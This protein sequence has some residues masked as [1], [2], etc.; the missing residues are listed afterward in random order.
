[1]ARRAY[2]GLPHRVN[3]R[4]KEAKGLAMAVVPVYDPG[5]GGQAYDLVSH[6]WVVIEPTWAAFSKSVTDFG[7]SMYCTSNDRFAIYTRWT[8]GTPR[9][10]VVW[11]GKVLAGDTTAEGYITNESAA[12]LVVHDMTNLDALAIRR[13]GG[14]HSYT[15]DG[16]IAAGQSFCAGYRL[17]VGGYLDQELWLD[18]RYMPLTNTGT[19]YSHTVG[20]MRIGNDGGDG[21]NQ[22][23]TIC[24]GWNQDLINFVDLT[25]DPWI[26][27]RPTLVAVGLAPLGGVTVQP[28]AVSFTLSV[29]TPA[30]TADANITA[31]FLTYVLSVQ[32]PT[33]NTG[34]TFTADVLSYTFTVQTPTVITSGNVTVTPDPVTCAFTVQTPTV[35]TNAIVTADVLS[36]TFTVQT[37]T[38]KTGAAKILMARRAYPGL[39]HRI[40]WSRKESKGLV[41]AVIPLYDTGS[42]GRAYNLV[43]REWVTI[44]P[45]WSTFSKEVTDF[46]PGMRCFSVAKLEIN[47][48]WTP[49][50]RYSVVWAGKILSGSAGAG[51]ITNE[52][53]AGLIVHD[54]VNNDAL[55]I[56]RVGGQHSYTEDGVIAVNQSF[57]AGYRMNA[58]D[59]DDHGLWV[60]GTRLQLTTIGTGYTQTSS[61]LRVGNEGDDGSA[62]VCAICLG[63][64]QD[65]INFAD[66]TR[67]PWIPFYPTVIAIGM[68][69]SGNVLVQPDVISFT[70]T[71][72]TPTVIADVDVTVTP[73]AVTFT[74]AI[75]TPTVITDI[76]VTV[77]PDVVTYAF[78]VPAPVVNPGAVRVLMARRAYPG[79][80]HR[81]NWSR[82]EAKGLAMAV[83]PLYDT[84]S[85]GGRAYDL[86]TREWVAINPNWATFTKEITDFG[87][88]M[89]CDTNDRF[90]IYTRWIPGSRYSAI[91][92]GKILAGDTTAEGYIT[93][94][95]GAGLVVHDMTNNDSLAIRRVGGQHSYTIDGVI[96]AGQSFCAGYR[97]NISDKDDQELWLDGRFMPL[98]TT[99]TGFTHSAAA[100]RVG[101]EGGD[102][103]NQVCTICLGWDQDIINFVDLTRDPWI[104]FQP[105]L[106]AVGLTPSGNILVQP[107]TIS[108]TLG[109]Q[110]PTVISNCVL[111]TAD[112]TT[113]TLT[114]P[115]P[116][117]PSSQSFIV[118]VLPLTFTVPSPSVVTGVIASFT[119]SRLSG[120]APLG[121][122]FDASATT[123][124]D[125]TKTFHHLGYF[126]DLD[127]ASA[128]YPKVRGCIAAH[129][130]TEPGTYTVRLKVISP[131]GAYDTD[132]VV[133]TV[134]D[135]DV[136]FSGTDTIC[137]SASSDF[138][139]A[140][141]G[142]LHV[143]SSDFDY[144]WNTYLSTGK[145]LLFCRGD[146]FTA[147]SGVNCHFQG[148]ASA[149]THVG[150]YGPGESGGPDKYGIY[151]NDPVVD[152]DF[153]GDFIGCRFDNFTMCNLAFWSDVGQA[154]NVLHD[155]SVANTSNNDG[156]FHA[157]SMEGIEMFTGIANDLSIYWWGL[158][159]SYLHHTNMIYSNLYCSTNTDSMMFYCSGELMG[160][161]GCYKSGGSTTHICRMPQ[162]VKGCIWGCEWRTP[163]SYRHV[164]KLHAPT[165]GDAPS[166]YDVSEY[167]HIENNICEGPSDWLVT[168]GPQNAAVDERV[169]N[170]VFAGNKCLQS[171][172]G[173]VFIYNNASHFTARDNEFYSTGNMYDVDG[174]LITCR[175]VEPIPTGCEVYNNTFYATGTHTHI[176]SLN[177]QQHTGNI[178]LHNTVAQAADPG[179]TAHI[180]QGSAGLT[181]SHNEASSSTG[182]PY[183]FTNPGSEDVTLQ[184][185]STLADAGTVDLFG[186]PDRAGL[187]RVEDS[188]GPDIGCH[189]YGA[190]GAW[191]DVSVTVTP[192]VVTFAFAIQPP[193]IS[194]DVI[195]A[196]VLSLTFTIPS[197]TVN[198]DI[199][200]SVGVLPLTFTVLSPAVSTGVIASFAV[201]RLSG[202]APLGVMLDASATTSSDVTKTFHHL[203]YFWDLDDSNARYPRVRGC[204]ATHVFTEPGTYNI[205]L[206]VVSPQGNYSTDTATVTVSD[207]DVA[208]SGNA[209]IC[210]SSSSNFTGAPSGSLHVNSNDFDYVWNTYLSVGK[211][212]LF[213]R[214]DTFIASSL[215]NA[216]FQGGAVAPT[217]VGAYGPGES[218]G[219]N[220]YGIYSNDPI[221]DIDFDGDFISC[222]FD[223]F[224][225]YNLAFWSDVAGQ[226]PHILHDGS[227][228]NT[229]CNDGTF[230]ACSIE[231]IEMFTA[232]SNDV[233]LYYWK[234]GGNGYFHHTNIVY[235]NLYCDTHTNGMM[236]YC[237]GELMG[238]TGC[239][240][241]GGGDTHIC[242]MPQA[243]K[244]CIWGNE[245][246]Q[247]KTDR[248]VI[249]LHAPTQGDA[250]VGNDVSEYIH[251]E[252][253]TCAGPSDWLFTFGPQNAASDERVY[254]VVFAGNKCTQ[255]ANGQVV[256]YNNASHF[257]GRDNEFYS[258][259]TMS[260]IDGILITRRGVEPIPTDCEVY[261][262]TFYATG[263]HS[264]VYSLN[265]QQHIG[266]ILLYNTVVQATDP[267]AIGSVYQGSAP[268]I[269]S[270][271]EAS[272]ASAN[273]YLFT[274]P[275]ASDLTLQAASTLADAGT[276]TLFGVSDRAGLVRFKEPPGPDIGCH[277]YGAQSSWDDD[278][279]ISADLV[280]VAFAVLAPT[281]IASVKVTVS[282]DVLGVTF[283][284]LPPS[285]QIGGSAFVA[286]DVLLLDISVLIPQVTTGCRVLAEVSTLTFSIPI[287]GVSLGAV[288]V[289]LSDIEDG[290]L[291]LI[292]RV[293]NV[294]AVG[295]V[296]APPPAPTLEYDRPEQ[297]I[298]D[299]LRPWVP[300]DSG[301]RPWRVTKWP[302][303]YDVLG[304]PIYDEEEE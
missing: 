85:G 75:Q 278:V 245:W 289:N 201:S 51:F 6:E 271:N 173:Q 172:N 260:G 77:T 296:V 243:I 242:R 38:I 106:V 220:K 40:N 100:F 3:W 238:V 60:D 46:S 191:V 47:T 78:T 249:K 54:I 184:A 254:N 104:P 89:K 262:N 252:N 96:A 84:G 235:S 118:D 113:L 189:E 98:S 222:R 153:S 160:I 218:G 138:T 231:G 159:H 86:V 196:D 170:I 121:V 81:I 64:N 149:P 115:T 24:L 4:R 268:L 19:G 49:I 29:Q 139:G 136:T 57:C 39:P 251:I 232:L 236:L 174:V 206:K 274:N 227:I 120:V 23:C 12:G 131:T 219:P 295:T 119:T 76:D 176:Y 216:H 205:K 144:V 270:N 188:P 169:E 163:V 287:A 42:G 26:P 112:V 224:S 127:D 213:C 7:P 91:W 168:F 187:V 152:I 259:G 109:V 37:P 124:G 300:E 56:H 143:N 21:S 1:M 55:A 285:L 67:D 10:S 101:N 256:V 276:T 233:N 164:I 198:T 199:I 286:A 93:N 293:L 183:L 209:T 99:G 43:S 36:Y 195:A 63:W 97:L 223:N 214:G 156:T 298:L 155:G 261:N 150:A 212:L 177:A 125:V 185:A 204:I 247:P 161:T 41:M 123:S 230:H 210:V 221:I 301:A 137:A 258:T 148:G 154:T 116:T 151:S 140:P 244:T 44:D 103:S 111:V 73:D 181:Q 107:D 269:S 147:S 215:V 225:M 255:S 32:D 294:T 142:S 102:G 17:D 280:T 71:V 145:R 31:V 234:L 134:D 246:E 197:P 128:R 58:Q 146:T 122:M 130:F 186:V 193:T 27:F 303:G 178:L 180:Y 158:G 239:H 229:S 94:E 211:R 53:G 33:I 8:P 282:V 200:L 59:K 16:V 203:A 265:A 291:I 87:P 297:W 126:W 240:K 61:P 253:N 22:H 277:E 114:V 226:P 273:V 13:V 283:T 266:N 275:G 14:Q 83:I 292:F 133:I 74:F 179:A 20:L 88:A 82:K 302:K 66:L 267:G 15:A 28:D 208:F 110:A 192:G 92:A 9:Y 290:V 35:D 241:S 288:V 237:S 108:F 228:A 69:P 272:S 248:H 65:Q 264:H 304:Q 299:N 68:V 257:T 80:P 165:Q 30:I 202:P 135:P 18:G 70:L 217:Y 182:N 279:V 284:V 194:I 175:G 25:I 207:P 48:M 95:N 166:G 52:D 62:Q 72:Q 281:V 162:V 105:T 141:S 50:S 5:G 11:A 132:S 157:C 190:I 90:D 2:P 171:S 250:P 45:T 34:T 117:V 167:M 263:A 129:V 79:L